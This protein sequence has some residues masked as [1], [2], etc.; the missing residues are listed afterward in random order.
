MQLTVDHARFLAVWLEAV[1]FGINLVLFAGC[2]WLLNFKAGNGNKPIFLL[3]ALSLLVVLNAAHMI[4]TLEAADKAFFDHEDV[5]GAATS[6]YDDLAQPLDLFGQSIRGIV[7][8]IGDG[9]LIYRCWIIWQRQW[10]S[11]AAPIFLLTGTAITSYWIVLDDS[12]IDTIA[13]TVGTYSAQSTLL[14]P[15]TIVFFLATNFLTSVMIVL[16]IMLTTTGMK[17]HVGSPNTASQRVTNALSMIVESGA[18]L[19]LLLLI[20]LYFNL[21]GMA[22]EFVV[23]GPL[24]QLM[25]MVP[26]ITLIQANTGYSRCDAYKPQTTLER[27]VSGPSVGDNGRIQK[28]PVYNGRGSQIHTTGALSDDGT[29]VHHM[30]SPSSDYYPSQPNTWKK[31]DFDSSPGIDVIDLKRTPSCRTAPGLGRNPPTSAMSDIEGYVAGGGYYTE[32]PVEAKTPQIISPMRHQPSQRAVIVEPSTPMD[33]QSLEVTSPIRRVTRRASGMF[34]SSAAELKQLSPVGRVSRQ[35]SIAA[36]GQQVIPVTQTQPTSLEPPASHRSNQFPIS[37]RTNR[38]TSGTGFLPTPIERRD[39]LLDSPLTTVELEPPSPYRVEA[40]QLISPSRGKMGYSLGGMMPTLMERKEPLEPP[41]PYRPYALREHGQG[42]V[43]FPPRDVKHPLSPSRSSLMRDMFGPGIHPKSKERKQ[44]PEIMP[45]DRVDGDFE[46]QESRS[47]TVDDP[48]KT[49]KSTEGVWRD[50]FG[51][52]F[53]LPPAARTQQPSPPTEVGEREG[54]EVPDQ[55]PYRRSPGHTKRDTSAHVFQPAQDNRIQPS[56]P[57]R[58]VDDA[59]KVSLSRVQLDA[60]QEEERYQVQTSPYPTNHSQPAAVVPLTH[61]DQTEISATM[62][63][64]KKQAGRRSQLEAIPYHYPTKL[65]RAQV[66]ST[67]IQPVDRQPVQLT[68]AQ[69]LTRR[70]SILQPTTAANQPAIDPTTRQSVLQPLSRAFSQSSIA[71]PPTRLST[72]TSA[73]QPTNQQSNQ[74]PRSSQ[75]TTSRHSAQQSALPLENQLNS[76]GGPLVDEDEDEQP[77]YYEDAAPPRPPARQSR[78]ESAAMALGVVRGDVRRET[79][80]PK[81]PS[82]D[83]LQ[84]IQ[85]SPEDWIYGT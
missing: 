27:S 40:T 26:I 14:A 44:T 2:F 68:S 67:I 58:A 75:Q 24:T 11:I 65:L 46:L 35:P 3:T 13:S 23:T 64:S 42:E 63:I 85:D 49:V 6:Y 1:L 31:A 81:L 80:G 73:R 56:P 12:H 50:T 84:P 82:V 69:P 43:P 34:P 78:R 18:V 9:L 29:L 55:K 39:N 62:T 19:P 41:S 57:Y 72:L 83:S 36:V 22:A 51:G 33:P 45:S 7:I 8:V 38:G 5:I 76:S 54:S 30:R 4:G 28:T 16:G 25:L 79:L 77:F 61:E 70:Q 48:N 21:E 53:L 32:T 10:T 66:Q 37:P 20:A 17:K 60:Q 47:P 15:L 52:G 74:S 71:Q 59:K